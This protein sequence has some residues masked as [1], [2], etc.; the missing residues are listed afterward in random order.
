MWISFVFIVQ[1]SSEYYL[2]ML[3]YILLIPFYVKLLLLC[4]NMILCNDLFSLSSADT[5]FLSAFWPF[6]LTNF[7]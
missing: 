4:I 6:E 1:Y 2:I 7:H 3:W 5:G